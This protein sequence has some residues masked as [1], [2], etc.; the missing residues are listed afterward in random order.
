M[1]WTTFYI[2]KIIPEG[3]DEDIKNNFNMAEALIQYG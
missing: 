2:S 3:L 1:T